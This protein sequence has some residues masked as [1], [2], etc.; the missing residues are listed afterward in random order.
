MIHLKKNKSKKNLNLDKKESHLFNENRTLKTNMRVKTDT[1][2]L[3]EE[4]Q[5]E[6]KLAVK[7][8]GA[9]W[10]EV[11]KSKGFFSDIIAGLTVAAVTLPL[12][13]ALAVA[14]SLP[15]VTGFIAGLIGSGVAAIFGASSLQV[16]GPSVALSFLVLGINQSFGVVGVAACCLIVGITQI[17]LGILRS[18]KLIHFMPESVLAGFTTGV[19]LKLLDSQ[20]PDFLGFD[21]KV[22]SLLVMMRRSAWLHEVS[23]IAVFCGLFVACVVIATKHLKKFPAALLGIIIVT[24][25]SIHLNWNLARVGS[26]H[27]SLFSLSFPLV[28]DFQWIDLFIQSMPIALLASIETLLTATVL[29][30]MIHAKNLFNPNLELVG[31]GLANVS[32]GLFSGMPVS[33][34][35][36][37]SSVNVQSGAKTRLSLIFQALFILLTAVYLSQFIALVPLAA[38]AGLLCVVAT[39]LIDLNA[40]IHLCKTEKVGAFSFLCTMLGSITDH[41]MF[42][43]I[44]GLV[45]HFAY[46]FFVRGVRLTEVDQKKES[47]PDGIRAVLKGKAEVARRPEHYEISTKTHNWLMQIRE[48]SFV[49]KSS[50]V[51]KKAS[52]IGRVV[53]GANVHIAPE[54]S[55][56][57][58][59]GT[60]FFIG[61]NSNIQDGAVLHALKNKWVSVGPEQWAIFIGKSVSVA[62]QALVHGPCYIG[63]HTFIGFKAIVHDSVVGS[64]CYIGMGAIVVGVE[65]PDGRYVPHGMI[66]DTAEKVKGLPAV[67]DA[68]HDFNEDVV[69]VNRGLAEAYLQNHDNSKKSTKYFI[70]DSSGYSQENQF[71]HSERF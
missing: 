20:I 53:L 45:L 69:E 13:I 31:Q 21:N 52:M 23:W 42:G 5:S 38:L 50:F 19:G 59:E 35:V 57:A 27:S 15:P 36:V 55:V 11:L 44:V 68:H 58:D 41:L 24:A 10:A 14:C 2:E 63:D 1:L 37:R 49:T 51:H 48:K 67:S 6:L 62:H 7:D 54:S 43:L 17:L 71:Q 12:N 4:F 39:R 56:R 3:L 18:G 34:G 22:V 16:S 28:Q 40:F 30:R 61:S 8:L 32:V 9:A 26:I 29:D 60:P 65:I 46:Q 70:R 66:V 64:H 47:R 25:I 33:G